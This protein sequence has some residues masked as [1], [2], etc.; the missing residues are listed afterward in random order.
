M[1]EIL[2]S[3]EVGKN[4]LGPIMVEFLENTYNFLKGYDPSNTVVFFMARGG[5][6]IRC[7]FEEYLVQTNKTLEIVFKDFYASRISIAK[8]CYIKD[9]DHIIGYVAEQFKESTYEEMIYAICKHISIRED[10]KYKNEIVTIDGIKALIQDDEVG[11]TLNQYLEQQSKYFEY[12]IDRLSEGKK[13]III[14]DTGWLATSQENLMRA[15]P[16][17]FWTGYYFGK[18]D[19][20]SN[21]PWYFNKV[22]G[23]AVDKSRY[24]K[25]YIRAG[26][27]FYHHIIEAPLE[28]MI[29]S[30]EEYLYIGCDIEPNIDISKKMSEYMK[31]DFFKGINAYIKEKDKY[32]DIIL[33]SEKAYKRLVKIIMFPKKSDIEIL[34]V[35]KRGA[36]FGRNI[37]VAVVHPNKQKHYIGLRRRLRNVRHAIWKQGQ[38]VHEFPHSYRILQIVYFLFMYNRPIKP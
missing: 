15:Y 25:K 27:L 3:Y 29:S 20:Y 31:N 24:N 17:K 6:G 21:N 10:W 4:L 19:Y 34:E 38:M 32:G 33:E 37:Q 26:V 12:Y 30:T 36:D 5:F 9:T 16:N 13:N 11:H 35:G 18:W 23:G 22:H 28:P 7:L 1:L 14:I 2:N 8:G